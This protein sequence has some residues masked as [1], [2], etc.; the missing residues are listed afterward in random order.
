MAM[1]PDRW[2]KVKV[3]FEAA[4]DR[5]SEQRLGYLADV[6]PEDD[7]RTEVERL[8]ANLED[9]GSFLNSRAPSGTD[10]VA[11]QIES[12]FLA[13]LQVLA[14]RFKLIRF[15]AKGGMGEVYEAE[16]QE[17]QERVALK[18]V[19][20]ELLLDPNN[21]QRF[22]RE[23][24]LAKNVT[25]PN[26]CRTFDL[27]RHHDVQ[28]NSPRDLIFVS[29][30]LLVGETL[31]QHLRRRGRLSQ[32]EAL[33]LI[34]QIAGG[35][36][37][38]HSAGVV[39]RDFKPGNIVLVSQTA[40]PVR[41]V[42]TDFGLALRPGADG[43]TRISGSH[44]IVG[45]PAYMAP[46]QIEG[47]EV[48]TA[49]DIYA[50]GLV[51]HE[52]L[53]GSMPFPAETPLAMA[54]RRLSEPPQS[55]RSIVPE[56]DPNWEAVILRCLERD[57]AK[58][59]SSVSEVVQALAGPGPATEPES[60]INMRVLIRQ[61]KRPRIAIPVLLGLLTLVSLLSLW[62]H[63]AAKARWARDEAVP[64]ISYLVE[65]EKLSE[66]YAL[67]VQAER[68]IPRDPVLVKLWPAI[69]WSTSINTAPSGAS[70]YRKNYN[71]PDTAWEMVG[72]SPIEKR[73]FPLVDSQWKFELKGFATV[74]RATFPSDDS[75]T[76]T[77]DADGKAPTGTVRVELQNSPVDL[78]G[79]PGFQTLPGITLSDYWIDKF[80]VTNAEFK[81]FVD[82]GGYQ[83]QDYWKNEFREDGHVLSWEEAMKLFLDRTGRPGPAT[84]IQGE[85]PHGHEKYPVTGVSW[86]EA[87]AYA[88]FAGKLLPTVYHWKAA[89]SPAD[90]PSIIPASNFDGTGSAP[91]GKYGGMSWAGAFDM[92]GN[93]K[94]WTWNEASSDKRYILG[95]AWNEPT[96]MFYDADA[97]SPFERS[98]N[99][100]FRCAK[101]V[102]TSESAKAADP[103]TV[104]VRDYRSERPAS[105]QLFQVYKSLFFY[106]KTPLHAVV[107]PIQQTDDWKQEKITFDAAYGRERIIAYL[108]LPTRASPPFQTVVHF[109]GAA[110]LYERSSANLL[111]GYLSDFDFIIKSGRV[112]MFPVYKG[113]F[114]RWDDFKIGHR[115]SGS[116]RD[117]IIAWS[118]DLSRSIDYLETRPDI[119]HSKLAYEGLSM[120]AA[121]GAILPAIEDRLKVLIL[122]SPGFY[123]QRTLPEVDQLSFA[124]RV[125]APVLMLNGRFDFIFPLGPSQEP[126]FRFLGT[127]PEHKRRVVSDTGHDIPRVEMIKETLNWLDRYLGPVK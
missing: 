51:M 93:V 8:L 31:S 6:C 59:F 43:T 78:F 105:D 80:E 126:M 27:F 60:G 44:G 5:P 125:K 39:H 111:S 56:L 17:L 12:G 65:K 3:L 103:I 29:M 74:E 66:A 94:E 112:V 104:Q 113:M 7:L 124:P 76:V 90:G 22:K 122:I 26:V 120:G 67:A 85:Y 45:T 62:I 106:D 28:G 82:E 61:S 101:Y 77:M 89:A 54:L 110:A 52:M 41:A 86:F 79:L 83:K 30:E 13:P 97:R 50:F 1:T 36:S 18:L 127:P 121:M 9:A 88:E 33:P 95:G 118:K 23:V 57:P 47:R 99:F 96:Y 102:L 10:F 91:V 24:H 69:S 20:P 92:A 64:Q 38:A 114:E 49:T 42:I 35:M 119:D 25:H 48:T 4:L 71:A 37:A 63:R 123:L 75:M 53:T 73:R 98:A 107:E 55:P 19:R 34:T 32:S 58:R 68:Y 84:W 14:G 108:F 21:L 115:E 109:T 40:P 72:R 117:H 11:T 16:D 46:E 87:A 15:L 2:E 70:V 116:Y 100:G 81:R